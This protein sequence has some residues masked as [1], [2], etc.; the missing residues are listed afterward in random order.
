VQNL[1][2]THFHTFEVTPIQGDR[3][4]LDIE[5]SQIF[6]DFGYTLK[7]TAKPFFKTLIQL[8]EQ[9]NSSLE[10]ML[11]LGGNNLQLEALSS[12]NLA[13]KRLDYLAHYLIQQGVHPHLLNI[14][15]DERPLYHLR[16]I[17]HLK[18][19]LNK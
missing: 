3:V 6:E 4:A 16:F 14:S 9:E 17:F 19:T 7:Q 15:L 13:I 5:T 18:H 1:T 10:T 12:V 11:I 2:N 8:L